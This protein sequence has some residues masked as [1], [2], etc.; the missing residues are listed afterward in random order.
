MESILSKPPPAAANPPLTRNVPVEPR[1]SIVFADGV[2]GVQLISGNEIR[3]PRL[4]ASPEQRVI[5]NDDGMTA[6][7]EGVARFAPI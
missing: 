3:T 5:E 6:H 2:D 4:L 1:S 7:A